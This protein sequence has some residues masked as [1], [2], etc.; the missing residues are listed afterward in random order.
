MEAE[1]QPTGRGALHEPPTIL[2]TTAS[3]RQRA[4]S[5]PLEDER[6]TRRKEQRRGM[7]GSNYGT[8]LA[9]VLTPGEHL[10]GDVCRRTHRGLGARVEQRRLLFHTRNECKRGSLLENSY[11]F[12]SERFAE[13]SRLVQQFGIKM[14]V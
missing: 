7:D 4:G 10:G 13:N 11:R 3:T 12:G 8:D 9:V 2:H 5:G 6:G 1:C 14:G